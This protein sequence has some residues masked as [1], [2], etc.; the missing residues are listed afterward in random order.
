MISLTVNGTPFSTERADATLY[1]FLRNELR[2]KGVR[3]GGDNGANGSACVIVN[4]KAVN[5][6]AVKISELDGASVETV[7]GLKKGGVYHPLQKAFL[8]LDAFQCGYCTP[9]F[10]MEAKALLD[11]NPDPSADEVRKAIQGHVCR[12]TGYKRIVE[13][14]LLAAKELRGETVIDLTPADQGGMGAD[15]VRK[16]GPAKVTGEPI[17]TDDFAFD[18]MLEGKFVWPKYPHAKIL[19]VDTEEA[20]KMPGVAAIATAADIPGS[21]LFGQGFFP[22]QPVIA[23]DIVRYVGDPVAVVYAETLAQAEAA[24]EKVRVE[25]EPLPVLTDMDE[26]FQNDGLKVYPEYENGNICS[27]DHTHKGDIEKGFAMSDA[28]VE[29]DYT[30]SAIDHAYLEPDAAVSLY[31]DDGKLLV[32]GAEQNP[33]GLRRDIATC[34]GLAEEDVRVIVHPCGGGFGGREEP[35]VH[36]QAALGT[37]LTGRPVRIVFN[38]EEVNFFSTK[39]HAMHLHYKLGA[40]KDGTIQAIEIKTIGDTGAYMSSGPY[41]MFRA[42]AFGA[43]C[44][45]IPNAKIDTYAVYTNNT[46][47]GSMRGFGST[48]PTFALESLLDEL[49]EKIGMDPVAFRHKNGLRLGDQTVTGHVLDY[50]CGYLQCLEAV[51]EAVRKNGIPA[52]SGPHKKV[53]VGY[54]SSMKNVGLGSGFPDTA[55][56]QLWLAEDGRI[57]LSAGGAELGQ[58]HDTIA[59]QIAAEAIGVPY[60][61]I[62]ILPVDSSYTMDSGITTASRQTFM[63]GNACKGAGLAFRD[64]LVEAAAE[65]SGIGKSYLIFDRDRVAG[66]GPHRGYEISLPELGKTCAE[67]GIDV[68]AKFFYEAPRTMPLEACSDNYD[69]HIRHLHFAY[70][71]SAQ[72]AVVEVDEETG[73]VDVLK[74][75]AADDVGRAVNPSLV[76]GQIEGGVAM[77]IGMALKEAYIQD[78]NAEV[79]TKDLTSL[80]LPGALDVPMDL[81]PIIIEEG[82]PYGPFGAKGVGELPLNATAPAIANA[83]YDAVGV[84][85]HHLPMRPED[86][87]QAL[88]EKNR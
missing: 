50:S 27:H 34:L 18:N 88:K 69:N 10:L 17:F 48:Q 20:K 2:L 33:M 56:S 40:T 12:C 35:S 78:E 15:V 28:V 61:L 32:H 55:W 84:R 83:I 23:E 75:Y 26:A 63:S 79:V 65:V 80:H 39:R 60:S 25:Y 46:T 31:D 81:Y 71:F 11:K 76:A 44:Y 7:E 85:L 74:V 57:K 86:I 41:V 43:G 1:V 21:K 36:I 70:D 54:A 22:Q 9:G 62:D 19:S 4:G 6:C 47:A 14:V 3:D 49:A 82:H 29:G 52:P 13:A 45:H 5:S 67:K 59:V 58:G 42:C 72:A 16:D 38:R 87:L 64:K 53:G 73:K 30:T 8:K 68:Y 77:G 24:A 37:L 66:I 51:A